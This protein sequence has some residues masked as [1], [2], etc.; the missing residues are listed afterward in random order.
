MRKFYWE[1]SHIF[2][3]PATLDRPSM[4]LLLHI[5]F[6]VTLV[7]C[8]NRQGGTLK[9]KVTNDKTAPTF[10]RLA[11]RNASFPLSLTD[12]DFRDT[13]NIEVFNDGIERKIT[14]TINEI[15]YN[16]CGGDS[17]QTYFSIDD[18]YIGTLRLRDSLQSIFMIIF[19]HIP[20][21]LDSK[22]LFYDMGSKEFADRALDF[23][24][25]GL[26][27]FD[28]LK[29]TPTNLKEQ[30][31]IMT[32]E[33]ELVDFNKDGVNDYK[34]TRLYHNGTA[35]AIETAVIKVSNNKIDTLDFKQKWIR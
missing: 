3:L 27:D 8:S 34:F 29:L 15:Y 6:I 19:Q 17:N 31:K 11:I 22:I 1:L 23:K 12:I 10:P 14:N 35:N 4:K 9:E 21:G 7:S 13:K 5:F 33:I 32:P 24:I 18:T 20:G 30:F 16:D 26:Y 2:E 28:S 25:H